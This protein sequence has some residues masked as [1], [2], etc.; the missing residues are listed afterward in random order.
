MVAQSRDLLAQGISISEQLLREARKQ[1]STLVDDRM[2]MLQLYRKR[3]ERTVETSSSRLSWKELASEISDSRVVFVG[4]FG[5]SP[6]PKALVRKLIKEFPDCMLALN[7]PSCEYQLVLDAFMEG[8]IP[9]RGLGGRLSFTEHRPQFVWRDYRMILELARE[10]RIPTFLFEP[11]KFTTLARKDDDSLVLLEAMLATFPNRPLIVLAGEIRLSAASLLTPVQKLVGSRG[12]SALYTDLAHPY[13]DDIAGGG[14]GRGCFK[15]GPLKFSVCRQS[16]LAKLQ[17][18]LAWHAWDEIPLRSDRLGWHFSRFMRA[19][20]AAFGLPETTRR[21]IE[22]LEPG[23][24]RFL[25]KLNAESKLTRAQADFLSERLLAGESRCVPEHNL[26]YIGNITA[27]H[28]AEEAAHSVR[29]LAG[30]ALYC[31]EG[32]DAFWG[33]AVH[34]LLAFV[35]SKVVMP[36]R[37]PPGVGGLKVTGPARS[38][39]LAHLFGYNLGERLFRLFQQD[40]RAVELVKRMFVQD[41]VEPEAAKALYFEAVELVSGERT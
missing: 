26:A 34:E 9:A 38:E 11:E 7:I 8:R 30:G 5:T 21:R 17:T 3:F 16:P 33:V 24:P 27:S 12:V 35:G 15:L 31:T 29:A 36:A 20:S 40:R 39:A 13:L 28:V 25:Q 1:V 10:R 41:L 2:P 37:T 32:E 6:Q 19:I 23:D 22:L 4:D 14:S 18:F